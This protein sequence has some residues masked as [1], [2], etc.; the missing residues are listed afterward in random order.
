MSDVSLTV[1]ITSTEIEKQNY[2]WQAQR[3]IYAAENSNLKISC[4]IGCISLVMAILRCWRVPMLF[5]GVLITP[6]RALLSWAEHIQCPFVMNAVV[7]SYWFTLFNLPYCSARYFEYYS[8]ILLS[9]LMPLNFRGKSCTCYS[10]Y[11]Y[12][13][14]VVTSLFT[15]Y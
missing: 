4:G 9:T 11:I 7:Q 8:L 5:R 6:C 10:S 2:G 13:K 14:A 15:A 3:N 12:V 1:S